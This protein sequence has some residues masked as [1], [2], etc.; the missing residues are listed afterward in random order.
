MDSERVCSLCGVGI[1]ISMSASRPPPTFPLEQ[2]LLM[3]AGKA[4]NLMEK[5]KLHESSHG[6]TRIEASQ[7]L[8]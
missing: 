7:I 4:D 3:A 2:A 8:F 6:P 1:F 5:V